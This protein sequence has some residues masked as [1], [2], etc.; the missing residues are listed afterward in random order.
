[1]CGS[2]TTWLTAPAQKELYSSS[3]FHY[4]A[5]KDSRVHLSDTVVPTVQRQHLEGVSG[6]QT[7]E[8]SSAGAETSLAPS[9]PTQLATDEG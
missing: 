7:D 9:H 4:P 5:D 6:L 8:G 1:M 2:I 3:W